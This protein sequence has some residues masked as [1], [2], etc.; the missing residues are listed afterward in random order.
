MKTKVKTIYYCDHC[1]KNY[2]TKSGCAKHEEVCFHNPT[3]DR[4][5]FHC[6]HLTKKQVDYYYEMYDGEHKR[7]LELMYCEKLDKFVYPPIVEVKRNFFD[8]GDYYNDPMPK[9]CPD[10]TQTVDYH[11]ILKI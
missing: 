2:F 10:Q 11:M 5:C 6:E 4:P 9:E 8:L 1:N 3:N 7:T